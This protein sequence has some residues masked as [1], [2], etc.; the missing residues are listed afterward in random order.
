MLHI[1]TSGVAASLGGVGAGMVLSL[2]A[3]R[4]LKSEIYGVTPW[5]P[6]T[7]TLVPVA[8]VLLALSASVL[9]VL[10]ISR[11]QPADTLRYE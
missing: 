10:R 11:I 5:D 7:L 8:L 1:G 3:L 6:I 4:L 9:P 2:F